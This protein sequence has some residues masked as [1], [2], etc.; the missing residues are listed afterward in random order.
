LL[1]PF[2]FLPGANMAIPVIGLTTYNE[3]NTYGFPVA[4]LM[5]QYIHAIIEAG[6]APV[7][8]PSGIKEDGCQSLLESLDGLLLTGGGDIAID[9]FD[10][11]YHPSLEKIDPDR[12]AIEFTLLQAAAESGKPFLGICR[13][14]QVV[15]VALGG[16]LYTD[17]QDQFPGAL[18]H[19]Y[20][21]GSQRQFLAHGVEVDKSS[22]L[23]GILG[24]NRIKVNSLHH[25]GI[26]TLS[27]SLQPVA[28]AP[29]GLVEAVE[30]P[31]HPFGL[32]VQW[33]PEWLTD[34]LAA[35]R[36]FRAFVVAAGT[37]K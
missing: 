22:R 36:L 19:D 2:R 7:L 5:H 30:I 3:E 10:G 12:D 33:H 14:N 32:A 21:S 11:E 18:K 28:H 16:S 23:A 26:K 1:R 4:M 17:I 8:I 20:D 31:H 9:R 13:G 29:D 35:Q 15:N 24:E 37:S 25:Q 6:G 27:P 34:Q